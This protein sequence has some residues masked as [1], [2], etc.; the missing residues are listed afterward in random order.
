MEPSPPVTAPA[1]DRG[2]SPRARPAVHVR[3]ARLGDIGGLV[4]LYRG[5][6]ESSRRLYHP[7]PFDR[8]RLTF[9]F[10]FMVLSRPFLRV[11]LRLAPR[12]ALVLLIATVGDD[13][14]VVGYGNTA[15][16]RRP[17]GL[18]A[19]F[20]YLVDESTRGLG[21]G[22]RLHEEMIEAALALGVRRGGGM[23]VAEN[24]ANLRVLEKL[25]FTIRASDLVDA[26]AP[27]A[28]NFETDGDLEAIAQKW[29]TR[30][31]PDGAGTTGQA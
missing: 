15:F 3:R 10:L 1:A 19:I 6:P 7:F 28:R 27:G 14:R 17:L 22:T 24:A 20:G 12:W 4:R 18:K 13:P 11:F 5:Q 26:G 9:L 25:G 30:R 21:V 16:V 31:G 2:A 23:V 29:R 8:P